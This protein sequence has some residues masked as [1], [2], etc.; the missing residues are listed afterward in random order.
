VRSFLNMQ[1]ID[2]GFVPRPMVLTTMAPGAVGYS[3]AQT[4]DFYRRLLDRLAAVPGV[5]RATMARHLPLNSLFGGGVTQE[6]DIPG[7]R[8][9]AGETSLRVRYN[10]VE[11]GYL[12]TMGTRLLQGRDFAAT[13][14]PESAG[15]V[16]INQTMA[17]RYW[18]DGNPVGRHLTLIGGTQPTAKRDCEVIG[19]V[20]DGKYLGLVEET[21]PYLYVLYAQQPAGEMTVIARVS[22]DAGPMRSILRL[23]VAEMDPAMPIMQ[24]TTIEEHMRF[25]LAGQRLVAW[26]VAALGGLGLLLSVVGLY[27]V[28]AFLVSRRTRD[29]GVRVALGATPGD[30]EREIIRLAGQL[31]LVGI[32]I[33]AGLAALAMRVAGHGLHGVSPWDPATYAGASA[34]VL[35]VALTAA[36]GPARRATRI[37]PI[38]ALRAE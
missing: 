1:R 23:I 15:V 3:R 29:I 10:T 11:R 13:D 21:P 12:E 31:A 24:V 4:A 25:A 38:T 36:Y 32:A 14:G 16:M 5:E 17:R 8:P 6:V 2:P 9:P 37:D 19:I 18:P 28:V 22:G 26:F 34:L 27:G 35:V 20:Q 30:V 33:G 7:Y